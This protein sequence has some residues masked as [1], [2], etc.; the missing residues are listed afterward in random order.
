MEITSKPYLSLSESE[1]RKAD[2][3]EPVTFTGTKDEVFQCEAVPLEGYEISTYVVIE[4]GQEVSV[5]EN[6]LQGQAS[7]QKELAIGDQAMEVHIE[8][9]QKEAIEQPVEEEKAQNLDPALSE[10]KDTGKQETESDPVKPKKQKETS[11]QESKEE[12]T[13]TKETTD[14]DADRK[15]LTKEG[16][17]ETSDMVRTERGRRRYPAFCTGMEAHAATCRNGSICLCRLYRIAGMA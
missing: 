14:P 10:E 6:E 2:T 9:R 5:P 11:K 12:K 17:N 8:F 15:A 3:G 1:I 4:D 13:E 16:T 7:Y